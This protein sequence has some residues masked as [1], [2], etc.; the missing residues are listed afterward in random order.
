MGESGLAEGVTWMRALEK[1]Y[2]FISRGGKKEG[3]KVDP[4]PEF[5]MVMETLYEIHCLTRR[6]RPEVVPAIE[7]LVE[8]IR[9]QEDLVPEAEAFKQQETQQHKTVKEGAGKFP[10]AGEAAMGRRRGT[11]FGNA[12]NDANTRSGGRG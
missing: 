8:Q 4:P 12:T 6:K 11:Q 9:K 2:G 5:K 3:M 7:K 1:M 10:G